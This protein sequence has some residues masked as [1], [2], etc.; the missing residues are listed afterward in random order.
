MTIIVEYERV[1]GVFLVFR[2][3]RRGMKCELRPMNT[4]LIDPA[5]MRPICAS[6]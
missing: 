6:V 5:G 1:V 3:R 2:W 4:M